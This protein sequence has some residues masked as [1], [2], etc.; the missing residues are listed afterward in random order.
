MEKKGE[1][2]EKGGMINCER[3]QEAKDV[4]MKNISSFFFCIVHQNC[5]TPGLSGEQRGMWVVHVRSLNIVWK[6][7]YM[8]IFETLKLYNHG[9]AVIHLLRSSL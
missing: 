8:V 6:C 2:K 1:N 9:S 5:Q 7:N 3:L 4:T